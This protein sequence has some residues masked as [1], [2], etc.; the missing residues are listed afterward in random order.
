ML[1]TWAENAAQFAAGETVCGIVRSVEDYGVFIEL[2]PN[3]SGLAELRFPVAAGDLVSC[4]IKSILPE[5][6]K[7]KLNLIDRI[8]TAPVP[9]PPLPYFITSGHISCWQY[10]P[11]CC[12]ARHICTEFDAPSIEDL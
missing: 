9:P 4:Y 3:L 8:G 1:G 7:I 10:S 5:R 12:A 11:P 2:A 6:M